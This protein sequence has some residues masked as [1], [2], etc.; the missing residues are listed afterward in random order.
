MQRIRVLI[1]SN[2]Y[3]KHKRVHFRN[4]NSDTNVFVWL[5]RDGVNTRRLDKKLYIYIIFIKNSRVFQYRVEMTAT[6]I[7]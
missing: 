5:D 7:R 3:S 2:Y 6:D 1:T 4:N